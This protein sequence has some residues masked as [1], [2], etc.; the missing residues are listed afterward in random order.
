MARNPFTPGFGVSP[1]VLAGRADIIAEFTEA[2]Q[3]GPGS[4]AR[5]TLYAGA[6]GTGKTVML[7]QVGDQAAELGW[8]TIDETAHPG[9]IR[10]LV[11]EQLPR[12]LAEHDPEA[13]TTK[14]TGVSAPVV[15]G[16]LDWS[17]TQRHVVTPGLRDQLGRL[18][19]LLAA[20]GVGLLLTLDEVAKRDSGEAR[21]FFATLQHLIREGREI[22]FA[23]A[24]LPA[25]VSDLLHDDVLTFLRR[26]ER[27]EL[28][29]VG[30]G[31]V[32]RVMRETIEL[33][34]RTIGEEALRMAAE[35]T[36]GYPFLIQLIGHHIWRQHRDEPEITVDDVLAG[37]PAAMKR[38]GSLVH[39]EA[40]KDLSHVDRTFLLAMAQDD[41]PS[42]TGQIA[43]RLG[44]TPQYASTYRLRLLDARI[45]VT[46][47]YGRVDFALPYMRDYLRSHAAQIAHQE[48]TGEI[49]QP[50][51]PFGEPKA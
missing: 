6:R 46:A 34:G 47:G 37:I 4:P 21:E 32:A 50:T 31:E 41:G 5:A 44:V 26:A 8:L 12:L 1:P 42:Q 45:I 33:S 10:R 9:F 15:G 20:K 51:L 48:L 36:G 11:D 38:M 24:G 39:E 18:C 3:D 25:D 49:P 13:T 17:T 16:G 40:L 23:A 27:H 7:N 22:A 43:E 19:D 30:V 2:L 35:A 28:G 29:S 14:V